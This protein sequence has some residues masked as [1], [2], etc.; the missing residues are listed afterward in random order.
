MSLTSLTRTSTL[1][2]RNAVSFKTFPR[3]SSSV[4]RFSLVDLDFDFSSK[5][6]ILSLNRPPANS[7]NEQLLNEINA[8]IK[9]AEKESDCSAIVLT[10]AIPKIFCAGLDLTVLHNPDTKE[11]LRKFWEALQRC[12]LNLYGSPLATVAALNG[13]APA[14]GC[15]LA[16]S[17]DYRVMSSGTI[18]FNETQFGIMVPPFFADTMINTIGHRETEKLIHLGTL[19]SAKEA[20]DIGM[21]DEIV[22]SDELMLRSFEVAKTYAN[23]PFD[24]RS[25]TKQTVRQ[26]KIQRL[27]KCLEEDQKAFV[28]FVTSPTV[29]TGIGAYLQ[30]LKNKS[31]K[32]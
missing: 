17:C 2:Q 28:E 4:H 11:N 21:V 6:A 1:I 31:K 3:F 9:S 22:S 23:T 25:K 24:A 8:A 32:K 20:L 14:G 10:S 16:L 26:E 7:L 29:Q 30:S 12:W 5:V 13:H 15:L 19:L 27:V 18:G